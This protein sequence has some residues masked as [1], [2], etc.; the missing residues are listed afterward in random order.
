MA[1]AKMHALAKMLVEKNL[2]LREQLDFYMENGS[3][4][5]AQ[6]NQGP[7]ILF[8]RFQYDAIFSIER[9]SQS[10][11][12]ILALVGCWLIAF[13]SD[14]EAH[15]LP[16]PTFDITPL[17]VYTVDLEIKIP[18]LEDIVGA[19]D[20]GGLIELGGVSYSIQDKNIAIA[21]SVGVGDSPQRATDLVYKRP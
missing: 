2:F 8:G 10:A 17:D 16:P 20:A 3:L 19:P 6:K 14:R 15:D 13:D 1:L 12:V 21:D 4:D 5:Y 7:T 9:Y 18:F 11:D